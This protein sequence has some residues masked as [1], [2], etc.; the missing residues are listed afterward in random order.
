MYDAIRQEVKVGDKVVYK[1]N[2]VHSLGR[3]TNLITNV[4]GRPHAWVIP[5]S[6]PNEQVLVDLD[7]LIKVNE[8]FPN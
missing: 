4:R 5:L 7:Y 1:F 2:S 6:C 3:I 8:R